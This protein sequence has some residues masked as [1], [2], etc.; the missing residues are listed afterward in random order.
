MRALVVVLVALACA[1]PAQAQ[2][3]FGPL[4]SEEAG[5]LQRVGLTYRFEVADPLDSGRVQAEIWTGYSNIFESDSSAT[6]RLFLDLESLVTDLGVRWGASP[7]LEVGARLSLETT[8]AGALDRV[9]QGFHH[10]L[11]LPNGN[12]AKY[13]AGRY[14]QRLTENGRL[15]MDVPS[16]TL[17][18]ADVRFVAKWSAWRSDDGRGV[19]SVGGT[20]RLPTAD[21]LVGARRMDVALVALARRSWTSWHLHAAAGA[22]T[23]RASRDAADLLRPFGVFA[24]VALERRLGRRASGVAQL[25]AETPRF[26]GFDDPTLD[27]WPVNL[28]VGVTG[29]VRRDWFMEVSLKE[30]VLPDTPAADFTVGVGI[31]RR[32]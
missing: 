27:G 10:A 8:G 5:P 13:P 1:V 6:H 21:D 2:R 28:A 12:R 29:R 30:D 20:A 16:R 31:R 19:V 14:A 15:R 18:L 11:H 25:S 32:W 24:D 23:V 22:G 17:A 26:R 9:V 3:A 4:A 7:R